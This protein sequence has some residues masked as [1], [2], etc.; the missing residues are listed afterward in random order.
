MPP[1]VA[2]VGNSN[3]GKTIVAA[4]VI[5]ILVGQR[6]RVAAIKHCP[7]GHDID[8][9]NSDT[10]RLYRAGAATVIAVSPGKRTRVDKVEDDSSL[11][12][13][14][15]CLGPEVD[16]AIAEGFKTSAVPKVLVIDGTQ[17]PPRVENIIATVGPEATMSHL[18]NYHLEELD[19]LAAQ[20]RMHYL[21]VRQPAT[22]VSLVVDGTPI[23]LS[24]YPISA[25]TGVVEGFLSSLK[26][27]PPSPREIRITIRR[28]L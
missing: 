6:Y 14:V 21:E 7:H 22:S 3:S 13:I 8:R 17:P 2:V 19:K 16:M 12:A 5:E 11:E 18:P 28:C 23:P 15:S 9:P 20:L 24:K 26:G 27:V 10:D 4:S 25:V 1:V